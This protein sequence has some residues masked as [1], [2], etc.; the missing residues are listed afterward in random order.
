MLCFKAGSSRVKLSLWPFCGLIPGPTDTIWAAKLLRIKNFSAWM[1]YFAGRNGWPDTSKIYE[2][3]SGVFSC[4]GM[5]ELPRI[6][7]GM[8][9][10]T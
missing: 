5:A 4:H 7:L 10:A 2:M 1:R 6:L 9:E 8:N 3:R